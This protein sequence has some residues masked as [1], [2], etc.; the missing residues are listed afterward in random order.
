MITAPLVLSVINVLQ[1]VSYSRLEAEV[2][3]S[4]EGGSLKDTLEF[5][6]K[7]RLVRGLP[8]DE[9]RVTWKGQNSIGPEAV[10]RRRDILRM[11]RLARIA[12]ERRNEEEGRIS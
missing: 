10:S 2:G 12:D 11:W 3:K 9:Y 7:Q 1:P 8:N 6:V 5:L 4:A